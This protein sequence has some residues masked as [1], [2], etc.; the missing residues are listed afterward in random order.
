MTSVI[1]RC[2]VDLNH[3]TKRDAARYDKH[4]SISKDAIIKGNV[5]E[6]EEEDVSQ[7]NNNV[8]AYA[9]T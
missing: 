2:Y 5:T 6:N 8:Q 4:S 3:N 9:I 1:I 7:G